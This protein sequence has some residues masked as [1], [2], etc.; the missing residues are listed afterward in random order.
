VAAGRDHEPIALAGAD[1]PFVLEDL[2]V[3]VSAIQ[4]ETGAPSGA[5]SGTV[6]DAVTP[7][8]IVTVC[9]TEPRSLSSTT[10]CSPGERS[11]TV[12][13]DEPRAMPSTLTRAPPGSVRIC[14]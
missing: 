7:A 9:F 6:S 5:A 12:M 10:A 11:G 8:S 4:P 2:H 3:A 14:R 1:E 13:G